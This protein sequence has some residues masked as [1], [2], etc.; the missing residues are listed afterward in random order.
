MA[1]TELQKKAAYLFVENPG[2][3][4]GEVSEQVGVH[5]NT[6]TAWCKSKEFIAFKND[7]SM[8][9]HKNFLADT[10]K[11]LRDKTLDGK[12]RSHVKYLELALKSYGL[13]T[14]R[15]ESTVTVKEEKTEADLLAEL[16]KE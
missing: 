13:L 16:D 6:M 2:I 4:K 1:L 5:P 11:I 7:I 9:L 15:V 8:D 3:K 10:L 14:D 12:T